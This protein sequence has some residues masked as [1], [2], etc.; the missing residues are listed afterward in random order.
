M[1]QIAVVNGSVQENNYLGFALKILIS[2]LKKHKD[3]SIVEVN[4]KD[5]NLPFPGEKIENDDS[6]KLRKI[7]KTSDAYVLGTP[8][9]NGTF[10]AKL[11]LMIENSG[12]PSL[13]KDKPISLI[14]IASG[15]LGAVKSLEH[16]RSVCSHI[17]GFALPRAVSVSHVEDRFSEDG[18]SLDTMVEKEIRNLAKNLINFLTSINKHLSA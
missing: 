8:E 14:G 11:K 3:Y 7:L 13:L 1:T 17:G 16:L 5:F 10:T 6:P 9:Y 18:K 15:V 12:Y 4:L 2:E